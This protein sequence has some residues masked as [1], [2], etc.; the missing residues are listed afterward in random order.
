MRILSLLLITVCFSIGSFAQKL[1]WSKDYLDA[2]NIARTQN[3]S[4]IVFF[5]DGSDLE[6]Q[7]LVKQHFLKSKDLKAISGQFVFLE[8]DESTPDRPSSNNRTYNK[9]LITA[10]NP[11]RHFPALQLITI[12]TTTKPELITDISSARLKAFI[13]EL[14]TLN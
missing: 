14:R 8:I 9:R 2:M 7:R 1:N 5:T 12:N 11:D 4:I 10:Y 6:K 3:K 13:Q